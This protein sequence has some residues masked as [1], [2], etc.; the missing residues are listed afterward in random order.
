MATVGDDEIGKGDVIPD[1]N[2]LFLYVPPFPVPEDQLDAVPH[3]VFQSGQSDVANLST[4]WQAKRPDP[5]S[6]FHMDEGKTLVVEI[7]V[8][9]GIKNPVNTNQPSRPRPE[10]SWNQ[11][12]QYDPLTAEDDPRH[13]ANEAHALLIGSKKLGPAKVLAQFSRWFPRNNRTP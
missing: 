3:T 9:D 2:F 7:R 5:F 10:P 11:R 13:G 12:P 6:S 1:G 8:C 4:D